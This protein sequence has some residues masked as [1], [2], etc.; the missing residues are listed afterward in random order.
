VGFS[1]RRLGPR[2][3]PHEGPFFFNIPRPPDAALALCAVR[4]RGR[5]WG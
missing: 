1:K 4:F 5:Y 3:G 2:Q